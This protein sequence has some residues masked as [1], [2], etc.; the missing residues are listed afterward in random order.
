MPLSV[1]AILPRYLRNTELLNP[2]FGVGGLVHINQSGRCHACQC[3]CQCAVDKRFFARGVAFSG[4]FQDSLQNGGQA[5]KTENKIEV[6]LG[7]PG[8]LRRWQYWET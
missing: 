7:M 2:H 1:E 8:R 4:T 3:R 6:Q 5:K